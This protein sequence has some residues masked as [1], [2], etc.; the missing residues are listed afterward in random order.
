MGKCMMTVSHKTFE[1]L[2]AAMHC[3]AGSSARTNAMPGCRLRACAIIAA[4]ASNPT[5]G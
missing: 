5:A 3:N 4:E 1:K 2:A